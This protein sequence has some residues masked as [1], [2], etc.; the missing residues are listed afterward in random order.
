MKIAIFSLK[1]KEIKIPYIIIDQNG[2]ILEQ[3]NLPYLEGNLKFDETIDKIK[4]FF[5][6]KN[7]DKII[8][9]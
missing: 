4:D 9:F 6:G 7:V 1:L 5:R 2:S 3:G 8:K